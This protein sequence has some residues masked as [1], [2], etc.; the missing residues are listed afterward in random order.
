[1]WCGL[2]GLRDSGRSALAGETFAQPAIG[3][4]LCLA[5]LRRLEARRAVLLSDL[6]PELERIP[7]LV[8]QALGLHL[9]RRDVRRCDPVSHRRGAAEIGEQT[10]LDTLAL[11]CIRGAE[12]AYGTNRGR[13]GCSLS[14]RC[15]IQA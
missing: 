4:C 6:L 3:I 14:R 9:Q 13:G 12:L 10:G 7:A 15:W 2:L 5:R 11:G 1:L 8:L